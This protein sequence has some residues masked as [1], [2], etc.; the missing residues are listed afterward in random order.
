M[1]QKVLFKNIMIPDGPNDPESEP[2][3]HQAPDQENE[4]NRNEWITV[5]DKILFILVVR[6]SE[7]QNK[8]LYKRSTMSSRPEGDTLPPIHTLHFIIPVEK[9]LLWK[10]MMISLKPSLVSLLQKAISGHS[11]LKRRTLDSKS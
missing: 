10:Y 6:V 5:T 1:L 11:L 8:F 7:L 4:N 2:E 9:Y 3:V